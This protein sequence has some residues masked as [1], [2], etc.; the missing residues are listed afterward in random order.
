MVPLDVGLVR[1][2]AYF[3]GL[4]ENGLETAGSRRTVAVLSA[5]LRS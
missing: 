5:A 2:I 1:T 4:L 3:E